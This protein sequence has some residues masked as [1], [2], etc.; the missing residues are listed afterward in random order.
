MKSFIIAII[1]GLSVGFGGQ[2]VA[3]WVQAPAGAPAS[4]RDVPINVS[5][6]PQTKSGNVSATIFGA[7]TEMR[8][9]RYCDARGDN[10]LTMPVSASGGVT[11]LSAG[12]GIVLSPTV[13]TASGT[14]SASNAVVQ[15]RITATCPVGQS[16]RAIN[17]DGSVVCQISPTNIPCIYKNQR[18][19]PGY[20]CRTGVGDMV[21]GC[22][23]PDFYMVCLSNGRWSSYSNSCSAMIDKPNCP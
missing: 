8:S 1:I 10:C 9:N 16:I 12:S 4:N 13:I 20:A 11:A 18:F 17:L 3:A 6:D 15:S 23:T 2:F 22:G 19:S 7:S 5:S 21:T 14:I